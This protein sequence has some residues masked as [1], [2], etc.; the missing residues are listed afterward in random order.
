MRYC[1]VEMTF[2]VVLKEWSVKHGA[3]GKE[4]SMGV[5]NLE[6]NFSN[7]RGGLKPSRGVEPPLNPS[8]LTTASW[9]GKV[10]C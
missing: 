3:Q 7:S 1:S 4:A 9:S 5:G 6:K 8:L 2:T 10:V